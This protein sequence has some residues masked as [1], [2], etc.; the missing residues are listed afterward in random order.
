[1]KENEGHYSINLTE[2]DLSSYDFAERIHKKLQEWGID[3]SRITFE[4]LEEIENIESL[5]IIKNMQDLRELGFESAI[6]D[7]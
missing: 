6:D 3:P 2:E 1:M 4:I 5:N 7:F